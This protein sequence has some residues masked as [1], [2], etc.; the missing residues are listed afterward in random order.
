VVQTWVNSRWKFISLPGQF[1]AEINTYG[2]LDGLD[3]HACLCD[4]AQI[5]IDQ[6]G[7]RPFLDDMIAALR[8]LWSLGPDWD[9]PAQFD[10]I[11]NL[12]RDILWF[13]GLLVSPA[14]GEEANINVWEPDLFDP[15][16]LGLERY[17]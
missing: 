3:D 4:E 2:H 9:D 12:A 5:A 14:E 7:F 1:S 11:A 17:W 15:H 6:A 10:I 8:R 16:D 13:G